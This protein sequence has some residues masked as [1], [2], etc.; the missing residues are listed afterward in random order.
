MKPKLGVFAE[1]AHEL[2]VAVDDLMHNLR[3]IS[4]E[5]DNLSKSRSVSPK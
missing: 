1:E 4:A 5:F 3:H 2:T